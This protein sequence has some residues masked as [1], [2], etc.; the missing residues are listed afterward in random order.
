MSRR[1]L[2]STFVLS[3]VAIACSSAQGSDL[4]AAITPEPIAVAAAAPTIATAASLAPANMGPWPVLIQDPNATPAP[5]GDSPLAEGADIAFAVDRQ[6]SRSLIVM[7]GDQTRLVARGRGLNSQLSP[8]GRYV[9]FSTVP[10]NSATDWFTIVD[11]TTGQTILDETVRIPYSEAGGLKAQTNYIVWSADSRHVATLVHATGLDESVVRVW[12]VNDGAA[13]LSAELSQLPG[14]FIGLSPDASTLVAEHDGYLSFS[15]TAREEWV[16]TTTPASSLP[17][18]YDWF[19]GASHQWSPDGTTIAALPR[20]SEGN[21]LVE[22]EFADLAAAT[23]S[24]MTV[25]DAEQVSLLGWHDG[26]LIL[27]RTLTYGG[28]DL[29]TLGRD[30]TVQTLSALRGVADISVAQDRLR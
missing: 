19:Y 14:P 4:N 24:L 1:F 5:L 7:S 11:I 26:D 25:P 13:A 18:E 30:G 16:M 6:S 9:A 28:V 20:P 21:H 22:V 12:G 17:A 8:N 23:W 27:Q 2:T 15:A 3:L 10:L 29:I